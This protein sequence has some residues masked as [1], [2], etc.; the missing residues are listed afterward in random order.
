MFKLTLSLI[1][2]YF[3][4][5]LGK[6][7][8]YTIAYSLFAILLGEIK[9]ILRYLVALQRWRCLMKVFEKS[10]VTVFRNIPNASMRRLMSAF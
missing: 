3:A 9:D 7:Q 10:Y 2:V 6:P 1:H 5:H 8:T 4:A